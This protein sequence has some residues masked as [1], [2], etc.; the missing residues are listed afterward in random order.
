MKGVYIHEL[1]FVD[2]NGL[3]KCFPIFFV[4]FSV[5]QVMF[6][7]YEELP[8]ESK[9]GM[10]DLLDLSLF[11]AFC[12]YSI[13]GIFGY[14]AFHQVEISAS[15]LKMM[16]S[17][18]INNIT[19]ICINT[20][21]LSGYPYMVIPCIHSINML[22]ITLKEGNYTDQDSFISR[23]IYTLYS[24][25]L[26]I[27]IV[28]VA[29]LIPNIAFVLSLTGATTGIICCFIWPSM[30]FIIVQPKYK[31]YRYNFAKVFLFLCILLLIICTITTMSEYQPTKQDIDFSETTKL[32]QNKND[33][34]IL[35]SEELR[36]HTYSNVENFDLPEEKKRKTRVEP[37]NPE[38]YVSKENKILKT[39]KNSTK[40]SKLRK[41]VKLLNL[42]N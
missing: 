32:I 9:E 5:Q 33:E 22:L 1:K 31:N 24:I 36:T 27:L 8:K 38:N 18:F 16:P 15:F 42:T 40:N 13:V 19:M 37:P 11:L 39:M 14:L 30:I 35:V 21:I 41:F 6:Y 4:S 28:I 10:L 3:F 23:N 34:K 17:S 12:L 29:G 7:L 25:T 26:M 20:F 2:F